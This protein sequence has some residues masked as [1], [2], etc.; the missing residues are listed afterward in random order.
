MP[1]LILPSRY[2]R[3]RRL[4]QGGGGEVW[5]V[6][7]RY[8]GRLLALKVLAPD[9]SEREMAS[10]VREAVSLSGLEGL[11]VPSVL[12]FGRLEDKRPYLVRELVEGTSLEKLVDSGT[13][14]RRAL[15]AL[16]YAAAQLTLVHRAGFL[17]GDV[18]PANIIVN[19]DGTATLVDLGLAAPWQEGGTAPE[20]LTPRYAA[21]ELFEGRP[22]TVR[23]EVFALG[24][25]LQETLDKGKLSRPSSEVCEEL[26]AIARKARSSDPRK[27][28]PSADE[29]AEALRL[30]L[31]AVKR[32]HSTSADAIWPIVGMDTPSGRLAD[33]VHALKPGRAL[34]VKGPPESGRS[35]LLRRLS[36][37]LGVGDTP[38]VWVDRPLADDSTALQGE[39]EEKSQPTLIVDDVESLPKAARNFLAAKLGQGARLVF[40]GDAALVDGADVFEMRPLP[41][42]LADELLRRA[43][44]SLTKGLRRRLIETI[45]GWP[46][47]LRKTVRLIEQRAVASDADLD[48]I[49]TP[50][51]PPPSANS[52]DRLSEA[53]LLLD[54]GR[55]A[56][57]HH[58]LKAPEG[59]EST[60]LAIA[61]ARLFLGLGDA[62]RA[63][64]S[65]EEVETS[66]LE[67][68][69]L[70]PSWQ[71]YFARAQFALGDYEQT[72]AVAESLTER[73]DWIGAEALAY[74]GVALSFL[75]RLEEADDCLRR[76]VMQAE[77]L[78]SARTLALCLACVG[79]ALQGSDK[80]EEAREHYQRGLKAAIEAEDAG[81]IATLQL[82]LAGLYKVGGEIAQAIEGFE[83]AVDMGRRSGRLATVRNALLNL[84]NLDLY[85]GR[86]ARARASLEALAQELDELPAMVR[87]QYLGLRA[88]L[89]LKAGDIADAVASF[90][91]S[92]E[93]YHKAGR[94]KDSAEAR[95]EG[96]IAACLDSSSEASLI[97]S[98]L[99]GALEQLEGASAHRPLSLV[100]QAKLAAFRGDPAAARKLYDAA[101]KA[102]REANQ[103]EWTWRALA[104]RARLAEEAGLMVRARQ[105]REEALALL[106][107]IGARL[108]RDLREVYWNDPRRAELR[109]SVRQ[110]LSY[111]VTEY[112]AISS[113]DGTLSGPPQTALERRLA[114]ILEINAA[115]AGEVDLARLTA[116]VTDFAVEL[117][118]AER[119]YVVLVEKSGELRLFSSRTTGG[120]DPR[121]E[122]SRSIAR[123]VIESMKPVVSLSARDD[124]QMAGYASVH[125]LMLQAVACVPVRAP[126]GQAIGAFIR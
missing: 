80:V 78:T 57:A 75:G 112:G 35:V 16:A 1:D 11:G 62:R 30:A 61:R 25:A 36:W 84:A 120:D 106:E 64:A 20:G 17:H 49:L 103:R 21:P 65:L 74:R 50:S 19:D 54:R 71:L 45:G 111:A 82:N 63:L 7:D 14:V 5:A 108:P 70:R 83:A 29:F 52:D 86:L 73:E 95:L 8:T 37:S 125:E 77:T 56:E 41:V 93:A 4:G 76:A 68:G 53:N 34:W 47:K 87:A 104:E 107:E 119:G 51:V 124:A 113:D 90:E 12:R 100:A 43:V 96:V 33:A 27:R 10:L 102:A 38:V 101:L 2:A 60:S 91:A 67:E 94:D 117:L 126:S 122:F 66:I 13:A 116:R 114:R 85:L 69:D 105:D 9:A 81:L 6:R 123:K 58:L 26:E 24:T 22:L 110:L 18:K 79:V 32:E 31:G 44:P 72:L 23:A 40:A 99:Q 92:A 89:E 121:A 42:D 59:V 88:E 109:R 3:V 46:G 15:V 118:R 115:L 39:V 48:R 97:A 28:H 98:R 55:Y